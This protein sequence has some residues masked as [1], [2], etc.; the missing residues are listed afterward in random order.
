MDLII[1]ACAQMGK[2]TYIIFYLLAE[3]AWNHCTHQHP[4]NS[5]S[6]HYLIKGTRAL[7]CKWLILVQG[8]R[9]CEMSLEHLVVQKI[10]KCS[11]SKRMGACERDTAGNLKELL[12]L[13]LE[14]L[15]Q[16]NN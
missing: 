7:W 10:R 4:D 9:K 15:G 1:D 14:Q 5:F 13:K 11:K 12:I 2:Y 16:E 3:K 6:Y 8:Q